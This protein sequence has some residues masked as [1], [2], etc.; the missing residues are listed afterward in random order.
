MV[1]DEETRR[2]GVDRLK[3]GAPWSTGANVTA[4]RAG[5]RFTSREYLQGQYFS[6]ERK[7]THFKIELIRR[8]VFSI[9]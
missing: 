9:Q 1:A 2:R 5:S 3:L 7:G 4:S 8:Y 6:D